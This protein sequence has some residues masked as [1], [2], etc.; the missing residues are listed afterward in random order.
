M[1]DLSTEKKVSL[2]ELSEILKY[3]E[4]TIRKIGKELY[5]ELFL[6][7]VKTYL[8]EKEVTN[9]KLHLG[10]NSELPKTNLEKQLIIKQAMIIQ[11]EII[12]DLE[13]EIKIL[14]PK[15]IEFDSFMSAEGYQT[16]NEVAKMLGIGRNI[17]MAIL[18]NNKVLMDDNTP[19][20]IY[21]PRGF[22]V[23]EKVFNGMK[24]PQTVINSDGIELIRKIINKNN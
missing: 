12:N 24:I 13:K 19:Y 6:N 1:K 11:Q 5:P 17:L 4:S 18:R 15:A 21:I 22:K 3:D 10:K 9:I 7:G 20:Q 16:F 8:S 23:I 14:K 2:K